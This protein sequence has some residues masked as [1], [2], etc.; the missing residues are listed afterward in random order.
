MSENYSHLSAELLIEV[1]MGTGSRETDSDEY[2]HFLATYSIKMSE[3]S[4]LVTT[5]SI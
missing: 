3:N 5:L 1:K 2:P 4:L